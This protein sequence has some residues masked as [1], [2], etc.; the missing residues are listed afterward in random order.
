MKLYF[1]KKSSNK[2]IFIIRNIDWNDEF[3]ENSNNSEKF[4]F[5]RFQRNFL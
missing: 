1:Q 4:L 3:Y 5:E 2:T